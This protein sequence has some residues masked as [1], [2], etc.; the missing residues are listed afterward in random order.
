MATRRFTHQNAWEGGEV[1]PEV[2]KRHD[3]DVRRAGAGK[4][5]NMLI[6]RFGDLR[7]RPEWTKVVDWRIDWEASGIRAVAFRDV[8]GDFLMV[9]HNDGNTTGVT[10]ID[11]AGNVGE[12]P[13]VLGGNVEDGSPFNFAQAGRSLFIVSRT[14]PPQRFV[15]DDVTP[16]VSTGTFEKEGTADAFKFYKEVPWK[17]YCDKRVGTTAGNP[18]TPFETATTFPSKQAFTIWAVDSNADLR[19]HFHTSGDLNKIR[20]LGK[21][22]TIAVIH[23]AHE[24]ELTEE[25]PESFGSPA[26]AEDTAGSKDI[27]ASIGFGLPIARPWPVDSQTVSFPVANTITDEQVSYTVGGSATPLFHP[28]VVSFYQGRLVLGSVLWPSGATT[29]PPD[30]LAMRVWMSSLYDLHVIVPADSYP[31]SGEIPDDAPIEVDLW[32][33]SDDRILWSRVA[34]GLYFGTKSGVWAVTG[35]QQGAIS[36]S[37]IGFK[38]VSG[39]GATPVT[40]PVVIRQSLVYVNRDQRSVAAMPLDSGDGGLNAQDITPHADHLVED[41]VSLAVF[42]PTTFDPLTRLYAIKDGEAEAVVVTQEPGELPNVS[43]ILPP[44]NTL[45]KQFVE[46]GGELYLF[47]ERDGTHMALLKADDAATDYLLDLREEPAAITDAA[48]DAVTN[49]TI[50]I[51]SAAAFNASTGDNIVIKDGADKGRY[52]VVTVNSAN[53]VDL[54][55]AMTATDTGISW[56]REQKAWTM[57]D[58]H[59]SGEE[60]IVVGKRF[61]L[62]DGAAG[63]FAVREQVTAAGLVLT[64][65]TPMKE[66]IYGLPVDVEF[67]PLLGVSGDER[68]GSINRRQRLISVSFDVKDT[69]HFYIDEESFGKLFAP[70]FEADPVALD[71]VYKRNYLGWAEDR[72][73]RVR[74]AQP[75]HLK[76]LNMTQEIGV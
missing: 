8:D 4:I 71:K 25:V 12:F 66:I 2:A 3:M 20:L 1:S 53:S 58:A 68:G 15:E 7:T 28:T 26:I 64:L 46:F 52:E 21:E 23:S 75:H 6:G 73:I 49:S 69:R 24:I 65:A 38:R 14:A 34:N 22:F 11:E 63:S 27:P 37:T 31:P 32:G 47:A 39:V 13:N 19:N 36:S 9:F 33:D 56:E 18:D 10:K 54:D 29:A 5:Q 51:T 45:A 55:K 50:T 48:A 43:R 74:S 41:I 72:T 59:L 70:P 61:S 42:P 16:S 76:I 44:V 17:V 30:Q 67:E 40:P 60:I 57:T 62:P 35:D